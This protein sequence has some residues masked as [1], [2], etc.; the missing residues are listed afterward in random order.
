M[1]EKNVSSLQTVQSKEW[2]GQIG[3]IQCNVDKESVYSTKGSPCGPLAIARVLVLSWEICKLSRVVVYQLPEIT[4]FTSAHCFRSRSIIIFF[5]KNF[6]L[7][8][9][10]MKIVQ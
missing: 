9:Y 5:G 1:Q 7:R 2:N 6:L 8:R 10:S 4:Q 3:P